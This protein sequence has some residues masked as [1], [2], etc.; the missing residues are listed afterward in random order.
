[1]PAPLVLGL[2][3]RSRGD[4]A[5][6]PLVADEVARRAPSGVDVHEAPEPLRLAE[7][8]AGR[9]LVVVLDA[10][11]GA[12]RPGAIAVHDVTDQPLPA[13]ASAA[14]S[15][16]GLSLGDVVELS[17]RLGSLPRRLVVVTV[18]GSAFDLGQAPQPSVTGAV[19]DAAQAVL[20]V[21]AGHPVRTA[22]T[23]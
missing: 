16:H 23:G 6:G 1:M 15:T 9:D 10:A 8:W 12:G 3:H 14:T 17:R 4:D 20:A 7:M 18:A 21:L 22:S 2:G 13:L 19:P 5:A 11:V